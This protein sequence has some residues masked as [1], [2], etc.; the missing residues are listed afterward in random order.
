MAYQYDATNG[1]IVGETATGTV[2]TDDKGRVLPEY[3]SER[4]L[5]IETVMQLRT[6]ADLVNGFFGDLKSGKIN[7]MQFMTGMFKR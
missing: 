1:E 7:P 5:L 6:I 2:P 3:L 4:E